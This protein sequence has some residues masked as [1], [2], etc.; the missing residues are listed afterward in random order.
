MKTKKLKK[1]KY[2]S[3]CQ[4]QPVIKKNSEAVEKLSKTIATRTKLTAGYY[5]GSGDHQEVTKVIGE[6]EDKLVAKAKP[7]A[8]LVS[9][10]AQVSS[11]RVSIDFGYA[12]NEGKWDGYNTV[13][14]IVLYS[15]SG[16]IG[17]ATLKKMVVD[18]KKWI[19]EGIAPEVIKEK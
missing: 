10:K 12:N 5:G 7:L 18:V 11:R 16:R 15:K 14:E 17:P 9:V 2:F 13:K 3:F 4:V 6:S 8:R 1:K 19:R